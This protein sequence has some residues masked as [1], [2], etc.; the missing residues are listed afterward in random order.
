MDYEEEDYQSTSTS[1]ETDFFSE[2]LLADSDEKFIDIIMKLKSDNEKFLSVYNSFKDYNEKKRT[3][4]RLKS[5]Q[6]RLAKLLSNLK[7]NDRY[8]ETES[9]KAILWFMKRFCIHHLLGP[10]K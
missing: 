2:L 8:A 5:I 3:S 4:S 9:Q 6:N 10:T 1:S 7:Q